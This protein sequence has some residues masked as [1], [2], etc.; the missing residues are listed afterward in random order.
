MMSL[1]AALPWLSK[2][3]MPSFAF[4]TAQPLPPAFLQCDCLPFHLVQFTGTNNTI[5]SQR[6]EVVGIVSANKSP[7][8]ENLLAPFLWQDGIRGDF[9]HPASFL[10]HGLQVLCSCYWPDA[11]FILASLCTLCG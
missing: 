10:P 5:L 8:A 9:Y 2:C 4:P 3:W 11:T 1:R 6:L 7:N